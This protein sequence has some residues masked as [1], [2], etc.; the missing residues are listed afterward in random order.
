MWCRNAAPFPIGLKLDLASNSPQTIWNRI[1]GEDTLSSIPTPSVHRFISL[2]LK[3]SSSVKFPLKVKFSF[4]ERLSLIIRDDY[5][6]EELLPIA[7][8]SASPKLRSL[9]L[10]VPA[11]ILSTK[12]LLPLSQITHLNLGE[13]EAIPP[14]TLHSIL[15][16]SSSLEHLNATIRNPDTA[17][18]APLLTHTI[19]LD[20][21]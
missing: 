18:T 14:Y 8:F 10:S 3:I 4:L 17:H 1:G 6:F 15:A 2:D 9:K 11:D 21:I 19:A 20:R 12:L 16:A 7:I 5:P 13:T